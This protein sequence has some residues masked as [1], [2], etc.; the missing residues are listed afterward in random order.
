MV[1]SSVTQEMP[2]R[3]KAFSFFVSF[4]D[5]GKMVSDAQRHQLFDAMGYYVF[6]G[7]VPS[8]NDPMLNMAWTLVQPNLDSSIKKSMN[9][10][11]GGRGRKSK[12]NSNSKSKASEKQTESKYPLLSSPNYSTTPLHSDSHSSHSQGEVEDTYSG[13]TTIVDAEGNT[14][15]VQN[16]PDIELEEEPIPF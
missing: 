8:F 10:Q 2:T 13:Y 7:V 16:G 1:D 3:P 9:G 4:W 11:K 12:S 5:V 15:S 14:V 6:E